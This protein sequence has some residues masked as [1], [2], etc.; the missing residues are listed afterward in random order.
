MSVKETNMTFPKYTNCRYLDAL[1]KKELVFDGAMG[2]SLQTQNLTAEHFVGSA[3]N[4]NPPEPESEI[5]NLHRKTRNGADF[6]LTQPIYRPED[7]P[8]F[9]EKY[10]AVHGPL[11]RPMLASSLPLVSLKHANF[12]HHE[13]PGVSIPEETRQRME[14]DGED[15]PRVGVELAVE[16][17]QETK[18]WAQGIYVMPQFNR[19][20]MVADIIEA[21]K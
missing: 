18:S 10:A 13:V 8:V 14:K 9:L 5:K 1:E 20:D 6:F 12:L 11:D 7:G 17:I 19:Y 3:L 21:V 16:L 15:G 4:L 2:T